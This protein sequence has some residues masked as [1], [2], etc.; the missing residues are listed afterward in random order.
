M[1]GTGALGLAVME[2]LRSRGRRVRIISRSGAAQAPPGIEVTGAD[3]ADPTGARAAC[4]NAAVVYHCAAP[5][6]VQWP[7]K[8]VPL[9]RGILEGA[10]EVG[11]G[12]VFGDN[13]Y[14]Y[15]VVSGPITKDLSYRPVGPNSR[16]RA[17]AA[18]M[19]MHAHGSGR[20]RAAIGRASDF[21][22][23]HARLSKVGERVFVPALRRRP[24]QVWAIPTCRTPTHSSA[25]SP[26]PWRRWASG[27]R[28]RA[29]S[30]M[31]RAHRP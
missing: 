6:Y 1:F 20:V 7:Q 8:F 12:L 21:F 5:P 16:A 18:A 25:T 31:C 24:A 10:T 11:A 29:K 23:P 13:L 26:G 17:E 9:T 14:A 15:G 30:G 19:V 28:H 22:G 3:P 27:T 4:R 2:E